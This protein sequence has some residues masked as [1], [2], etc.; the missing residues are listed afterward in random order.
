MKKYNEL[1]KYMP[2]KLQFF[3]ENGDTGQDE[4]GGED[5]DTGQEDDDSG[6]EDEKTFTQEDLDDAIAKRLAR[7][8]RKWKRQQE[9]AKETKEEPD[10]KDDKKVDKELQAKADRADVLETKILCYEQGVKKDAVNDVV[11][12]AKA[13][14]DDDTDI[15][16]AIEEVLEKYPQFKE[17]DDEQ[18]E[19]DGK[20][21]ISTKITGKKNKKKDTSMADIFRKANIRK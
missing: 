12:L 3:A 14:L 5:G 9:K 17:T 10:D 8:R 7:E 2:M 4:D 15:E 20:P 19:D 21:N 6:E 11:A 18:D 1:K 16:D 13:Y